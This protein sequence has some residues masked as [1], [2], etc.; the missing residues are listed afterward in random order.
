MGPSDN[1]QIIIKD[2]VVSVS[3]A[4]GETFNIDYKRMPKL[5]AL[6]EFLSSMDQ[7]SFYQELGEI[8]DGFAETISGSTTISYESV[9]KQITE[10]RV[11]SGNIGK[12][13]CQEL[14]WM[15]NL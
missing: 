10:Y 8:L 6:F 15:T 2:D 11:Y 1:L 5:A 9:Q 4:E 7:F 3:Y 12:K 13:I 14:V